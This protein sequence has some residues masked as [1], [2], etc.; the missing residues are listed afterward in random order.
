MDVVEIALV[1]RDL[2]DAWATH[3]ASETAGTAVS[4]GRH[5]PAC[6]STRHGRPLVTGRPDVHV[7]LARAGAQAVV[8]AARVPV[9]IDAEQSGAVD[10][11][12]LAA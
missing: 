5:C 8:A 7:S 12:A 2:V 6:G 3:L 4:L 1:E 9:G 11:D 10:A